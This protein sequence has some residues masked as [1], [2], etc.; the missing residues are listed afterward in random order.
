[1]SL[2]A[3]TAAP[4]EP[5]SA[6]AARRAHILDAA[7]ACFVRNGFHR[8]TMQ[9]LARE[10]AM[11]PGNIYRYF[12]SKE[13]VVLGLA[14]RDRERGAVLVEMLERAGD[15][16]GV[17]NGILAAYFSEMTRGAAILRLDLW[18]E[19]TRNPAIGAMIARGD[20][21]GRMWLIETFSA[22]APG[23]DAVGLFEAVA[24]LMKGLIVS[25]ALIPDYDAGPAIR[26]LLALI[27]AGFA[28]P[29]LAAEK[30]A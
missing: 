14:E 5:T 20:E 3:V 9:D 21:E 7:E 2:G 29:V 12:D 25:R 10:A 26:Q 6:Q 28:G 19:A 15:R 16:R 8:T 4:I 11:S 18:G 17:L 22:I 13:A 30:A 27:D 1:M 23:C 24:P